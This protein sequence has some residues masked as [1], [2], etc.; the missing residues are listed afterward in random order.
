MDE[1]YFKI[2]MCPFCGAEVEQELNF[3]ED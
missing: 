1:D 2:E 3:E